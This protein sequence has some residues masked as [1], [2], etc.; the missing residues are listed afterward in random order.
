MYFLAA[1]AVA[2]G[3][4]TVSALGVR[5]IQG[6]IRFVELLE[7]MGCIVQRGDT[8]ITVE[9]PP[10]GQKLC[11][12]DADLNDM[13]DMVPTLA[14]LALFADG[15][16]CIRDVANLRLKE[17][18]RL[19][20]LRTELTRLGATVHESSDGLRI[21]PPQ[22]ITPAAI[23]TYDDHRMA[24]SFALV[25]LAVPD[26]VINDPECCRKTFPGFFERYQG[27]ATWR[28]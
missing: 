2:G 6:D 18:D 7:V 1:P 26:M 25:G 23:D 14:V 15:P 16:T 27:L 20:A 22:A 13:P 11:A 5:S 24:M 28:R 19:A 17:T 12:V 21:T 8:H 3:R 9:G 4:V 10:S